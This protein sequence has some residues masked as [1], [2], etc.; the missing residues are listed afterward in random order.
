MRE[1]M[2]LIPSM[3]IA[4]PHLRNKPWINEKLSAN[5]AGSLPPIGKP[6]AEGLPA[7]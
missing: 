1:I 4:A 5:L 7:N 6:S 2:E 3:C